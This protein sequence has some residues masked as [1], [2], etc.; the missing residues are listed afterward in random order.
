MINTNTSQT[1][2]Q[3]QTIASY[4]DIFQFYTFFSQNTTIKITYDINEELMIPQI[5][6]F[7]TYFP[8][9]AIRKINI[10]NACNAHMM[11]FSKLSTVTNLV[12]SHPIT[13]TNFTLPPK[14]KSVELFN[15]DEKVDIRDSIYK[16]KYVLSRIKI[17]KKLKLRDIYFMIS[18][19]NLHTL[20][21][22]SDVV[23]MPSFESC[24]NLRRIK[25]EN[26]KNLV[27]F[28]GL[29]ENVERVTITECNKLV[30]MSFLRGCKKKLRVFDFCQF[31]GVVNFSGLEE[32]VNLRKLIIHCYSV[33]VLCFNVCGKEMG[34]LRVLNSVGIDVFNLLCGRNH[35]LRTVRVAKCVDFGM[36]EF[37]VGVGKLCLRDCGGMDVGKFGVI[38]GMLGL[39]VLSLC[40]VELV[41]LDDLVSLEELK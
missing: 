8:F 5:M 26:C 40:N 39:R 24:C 36:F 21:V 33:E 1:Q 29:P 9:V 38:S 4:L 20:Y 7:H 18:C 16:Y 22:A 11:Y 17:Y 25:F 32:C 34:K 30:D 37:C 23:I 12:T 3:T 19:P 6:Q 10:E 14:I 2:T 35:S 27:S 31:E 13:K 15:C 41:N 28:D